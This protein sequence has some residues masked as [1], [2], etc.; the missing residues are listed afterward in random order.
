MRR[1]PFGGWKRSVVGPG[2]KAGGPNYVASLGTWTDDDDLTADEFE[3]AVGRVWREELRAAD[4]SGLIAEANVLR[5]RAL[6]RALVRVG[7]DAGDRELALALAAARAVGVEVTV[8]SSRQR[9]GPGSR[10]GVTVEDEPALTR[11]LLTV[12][13]D[14]LRLIGAAG[15]ELRLAAHDAGLWVDDVEVVTDPRR[16]VLRWAREQAISETRHRHGNITG[17]HPGPPIGPGSRAGWEAT[18][19]GD[20]SALN[21]VGG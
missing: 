8:S 2:A 18:A 15:D 16:E 3:T 1:Q 20:R 12:N 17:R 7:E 19:R 21:A 6:R 4:A 13:V 11:R 9:L 14:K 5:Y 10:A